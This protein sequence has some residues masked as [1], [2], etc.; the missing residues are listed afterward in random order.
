MAGPLPPPLLSGR[1]TKKGPFFAASLTNYK[2]NLLNKQVS[3]FLFLT[4]GMWTRVRD[5]LHCGVHY[6]LPHD[7]HQPH[8]PHLRREAVHLNRDLRSGPVFYIY[9]PDRTRPRRRY[10]IYN[11]GLLFHPKRF[12]DMLS[13]LYHITKK[14]YETMV[15][16][17]FSEY[18][19]EKWR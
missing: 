5:R 1:A 14:I 7:Q 16:M 10:Q 17:M 6:P 11:G 8:H 9:G 4:G 3:I 13:F 18:D 19:W 12:C 15:L 2:I